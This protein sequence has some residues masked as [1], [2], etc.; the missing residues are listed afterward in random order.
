[1]CQSEVQ[2][3]GAGRGGKLIHERLPREIVSRSAKAPVSA[4]AQ[5]RIG[6]GRENPCIGYVVRRVDRGAARVYAGEIPRDE[7]AFGIQPAFALNDSGGA[8]VGP[9][10][11][12]GRTRSDGISKALAKSP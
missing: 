9:R 12:L 2:R 8:V 6:T 3:I 11:F 10:K 4:L 1:M 7:R 5:R